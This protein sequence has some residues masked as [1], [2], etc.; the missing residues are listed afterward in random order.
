MARIS[1]GVDIKQL[2]VHLGTLF[3]KTE[4]FLNMWMVDMKTSA[5]SLRMGKKREEASLW[6]RKGGRLIPG[7]ER[8]LTAT[9]AAWALASLLTKWGVVE[10]EGEN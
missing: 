4:S 6:Q 8:R 5:P 1:V 9:K 2:V 7:G 10:I 3:L